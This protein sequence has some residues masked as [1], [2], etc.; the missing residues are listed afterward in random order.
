VI[1]L[2]LVPGLVGTAQALGAYDP[3]VQT[4]ALLYNEAST[5][6]LGNL[7]RRDNGIPPLRWNRQLTYAA[8]WFSWDSTENRPA[9]FCDHQDT[10]GHWSVD[11]A[12]AFGYLGA[13][14]AENV[15]CGYLSPADA[16]QGWMN[17]SGHR[18]NLLDPNSREVGLG[19]YQRPGDGRGYVTQDFGNDSVYAPVVIEN[20]A[21]S[22]TNP[23]VNLYV[24]NRSTGGGFAGLSAA[25]Q[26]MVSNNALF[27]GA[28]W[29]PYS[30]NKAWTLASGAGWRNVYV[31]TRDVFTRT[32]TASD[33][34]YLGANTPLNELGE[35]QMS[36]T[37]PKVTLY[38]LNGGTLPWVQFSLGWLADDTF[39]TFAKWWGNGERVNDPAAS[40]GTSYRLYPGNGESYA[41][42][43]DTTFIKDTPLVAYF[44]LK[45]NNNTSSSEVAR[46]SVKGGGTEYGP[47]S[48]RGTDFTTP[49]QYQEFPVNFTFNTNPNDT[50]LTF[51]IW[52]NGSADVYFDDVSIFSA[53]QPI[54]S[55]MTWAVP[56]S[57]Y[58]GQGVW[59]RYT[60]GKQFSA[61]TEATTVVETYTISGNVGLAGITLSFVNGAP[62]T[63]LS[64]SNGNYTLTVPRGWNGTVTPSHSC[65]IFNPPNR[66]YSN[67]NTNQTGQ[68]YTAT[69]V[70]CVSSI[71]A[72]NANP[73][74]SAKVAFT[75]TFSKP[76]SGV[77]T[78]APFADFSL[79]TTGI[80][81]ASIT[82]V[83]GSGGAYTVTVNT[84]SGNGAIRLNVIDNDTILDA[85][86][87][88]L[89]GKGAG[90][91][92]FTTGQAYTINKT[93]TLN[94]IAAQDGW[95][96]GS[97][98]TSNV[99][100]SA[101]NSATTFYLGD[102]AAKKQYRGI[103]SFNTGASL[104][105]NAVITGVTLKVKKSAIVGGGNP[106][107]A[108]GGFI[109]DIKQGFFGT[110]L[111]QASDFQAA[112]SKSY[113]PFNTA[114]VGGWYSINLTGAGSFVNKLATASG[115]TQ[116]RLRF[117]LGDNNNT[118]AN[119]L[120]LYSGNALA[121]DRPQLVITYYVP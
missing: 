84:G 83:T 18:A 39:G 34:I 67:V 27:S 69:P 119:Y 88:P 77:D 86:S 33:T 56:G 85:A 68:N 60:N 110:A 87:N 59:A 80:T 120:S 45:V 35:T 2:S 75:V 10:Q 107:T 47:L 102:N 106:V 21:I 51:Q 79:S 90:N 55:P 62:T 16:I 7:A 71:V 23:N 81:N 70:P 43:Y 121:A 61:I 36:T 6:Y 52:R 101:N 93:L 13:A 95:V 96:L 100:G 1:L 99:G 115:L 82:N 17:S 98:E 26:M 112:A 104:P 63:V 54:T 49:N 76:V 5:V 46:I 30:A 28:T 89:G 31:K 14:G 57:N 74:N 91:G 116:I 92:N 42:V 78:S 53:P 3:T 19:Y 118:V 94:S 66:A 20:E 25:T 114:L 72:A 48:L 12:L 38:N 105:D 97:S 41:W 50:F 8:R 73:T 29:E 117:K 111:L 32:L 65:Y 103:L 4:Q 58:R 11:R 22:T 109:V 15:F 108:F 44:R 37:Q 113:G 64:D 24:Y 9:G 40:G